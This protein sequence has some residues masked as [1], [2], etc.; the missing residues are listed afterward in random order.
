MHT[1]PHPLPASRGSGD[2]D[3]RPQT[4]PTCNMPR[5]AVT[6]PHPPSRGECWLS[7]FSRVPLC[8][9]MDCSPPGSSVHGD[10]PGKITGM[11]CHP[12]P[13]DLPDPGIKPGSQVSCIGR[14]VFFFN[15]STTWE[16]PYQEVAGA[17]F[18][19]WAWPGD[20]LWP[21]GPLQSRLSRSFKKHLHAEACSLWLPRDPQ[22]LDNETTWSRDKLSQP[23]S[24]GQGA[25]QTL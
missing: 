23:R 18:S 19:S 21:T 8:S 7:C 5:H 25:C 2:C 4:T 6:P 16:D 12:P 13:G 1:Q 24:L 10:S 20:F 22:V 15:T 9:P 3:K 14:Q 11:G 17:G